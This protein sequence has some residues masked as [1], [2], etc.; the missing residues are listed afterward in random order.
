MHL[1]RLMYCGHFYCP[2]WTSKQWV[3]FLWDKA[4][5][6]GYKET[7]GGVWVFSP[8]EI[9]LA[10]VEL[11]PTIRTRFFQ[12]C[13][14]SNTQMELRKSPLIVHCITA[15]TSWARGP[16]GSPVMLVSISLNPFLVIVRYTCIYLKGSYIEWEERARARDSSSICWFTLRSPKCLPKDKTGP[17]QSSS[18]WVHRPKHL[19]HLPLFS[20]VC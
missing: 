4:P 5:N 17:D 10:H 6:W 15:V 19:G 12:N 13:Q 11:E 2:L 14:M 18:L 20:Q 8:R 1:G 7:I 3:Q 16:S 9:F